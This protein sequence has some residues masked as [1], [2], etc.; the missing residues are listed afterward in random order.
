[1]QEQSGEPHACD[2]NQLAGRRGV[3]LNPGIAQDNYWYQP[4]P[5]QQLSG[6][7]PIPLA[8][9]QGHY[10]TVAFLLPANGPPSV[11]ENNAVSI[12]MSFKTLTF[13]QH[14][15]RLTMD[16]HDSRNTQNF[17]GNLDI[18]DLVHPWP[19]W[20]NQSLICCWEMH[21]AQK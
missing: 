1:M 19:L 4:H 2:Q 5:N 12:A 14:N 20:N 6:T 15:P 18:K 9:L 17:G 7:Y 16:F 3:L 13:E 10:S 21:S 8:S 11:K